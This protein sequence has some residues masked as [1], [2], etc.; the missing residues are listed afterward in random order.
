MKT[1]K[2]IPDI[3][4]KVKDLDPDFRYV[5]F[6]D[7]KAFVETHRSLQNYSSDVAS[8]LYDGFFDQ[9]AD[10]RTIAVRNSATILPFMEDSDIITL[11][12]RV[13]KKLTVSDPN[14]QKVADSAAVALRS[15]ANVIKSFSSERHHIFHSAFNTLLS[16]TSKD[17][18]N[19]RISALE[20]L[21]TL[22]P[23]IE[24][25][26]LGCYSNLDG[27]FNAFLANMCHPAALVR[28]SCVSCLSAVASILPSKYLLE[29]MEQLIRMLE[30]T[31]NGLA[32][33][34]S[35][36]TA[37]KEIIRNTGT[38]TEKFINVLF[39]RSFELCVSLIPEDFSSAIGI[40]RDLQDDTLEAGLLLISQ[41]FVSFKD[42]QIHGLNDLIKQITEKCLS[43]MKFD[44][45]VVH[46]VPE[47][48]EHGFDGEGEFDDFEDF[49][50]E[51]GGEDEF[52][53]E[54]ETTDSSWKVRKG[55]VNVIRG[56]IDCQSFHHV[57]DDVSNAGFTIIS[58]VISWLQYERSVL[59]LSD[60]FD[61]CRTLVTKF[62]QSFT[63]EQA[64]ILL[65]S[66]AQHIHPAKDTR[67]EFVAF[68]TAESIVNSLDLEPCLVE[69]YSK[70]LEICKIKVQGL[71]VNND[72]SLCES[73]FGFICSTYSKIL[74][75]KEKIFNV[76]SFSFI[77][78]IVPFLSPIHTALLKS[79]NK[80][81]VCLSV[82]ARYLSHSDPNFDNIIDLLGQNA[83]KLLNSS[84]VDQTCK[85]SVLEL[86]KEVSIQKFD[87]FQ[88]ILIDSMIEKVSL[89]NLPISLYALRTFTTILNHFQQDSTRLR[90]IPSD[91]VFDAINAALFHL[92]MVQVPH[93]QA[94]LNFLHSIFWFNSGFVEQFSQNEQIV[95]YLIKTLNS[96]NTNVGLI[97]S[98]LA[99]ARYFINNSEVMKSIISLAK[100]GIKSP[101]LTQILI[102]VA[103][104]N[105][106][107]IEHLIF[108]LIQGKSFDVSFHIGHLLL[109]QNS[110]D[111]PELTEKL[112]GFVAENFST[113]SEAVIN[114]LYSLGYVSQ[115]IDLFEEL[116]VVV[117]EIL[118]NSSNQSFSIEFRSA[119][120][121][122]IGSF[123]TGSISK[124]LNNFTFPN[125]KK[126]SNNP[127][128]L[129]IY[130]S[131][132]YWTVSFMRKDLLNYLPDIFHQIIDPQL[133]SAC[134]G[135]VGQS[136][137]STVSDIIGRLLL[138]DPNQ[139]SSLVKSS[140]DS[141]KTCS[142]LEIVELIHVVL[143]NGLSF[144]LS[145]RSEINSVLAT[146]EICTV[147]DRSTIADVTFPVVLNCLSYF[148]DNISILRVCCEYFS[149]VLHSIPLV[150]SKFI[151]QELVD[152]FITQLNFKDEKFQKFKVKINIGP[153]PIEI[154]HHLPLRRL[155]IDVLSQLAHHDL[156]STP[157]VSNVLVVFASQSFQDQPEAAVP[158][159]TTFKTL[160]RD[161]RYYDTVATKAAPHAAYSIY[162]A[163][164]REK[165]EKLSPDESSLFDSKVKECLV[166][167]KMLT[168]IP[169]INENKNVKSVEKMINGASFKHKKL[170]S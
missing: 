122:L 133:L 97:S 44:P 88:N 163:L 47:S 58:S 32:V 55:S 90:S 10:V 155:C 152:Y 77:S 63:N 7:L 131:G 31:P 95:S 139:V 8:A 15:T 150:F 68:L 41:L 157:Q 3:L 2:P 1:A 96:G 165:P 5:A 135:D 57:F 164:R 154:D 43:W 107:Q 118:K 16:L 129:T 6:M 54:E 127:S 36:L 105:P 35:V 134:S 61:L 50:E 19:A 99:V 113:Q 75:C 20:C 160:A 148:P 71:E 4:P 158:A 128:L 168:Q 149:S 138:I 104:Q 26:V 93:Q 39:G 91:T 11:F 114:S 13:S 23:N 112:K 124:S 73:M 33:S 66:I 132:L 29:V 137:R 72:M 70:L 48:M 136:I 83:L 146:D 49:Q 12:E 167:F 161:S 106:T 79:L 159:I 51:F 81:V 9:I 117:D 103:K 22:L 74:S 34:K 119:L 52:V 60:V 140:L 82:L 169:G 147:S 86:V 98:C 100:Q 170:L 40:E 42:Q 62:H 141:I 38:S 30:G 121:W 78:A 80:V 65:E 111:L 67:L 142:N 166:V 125:I 130:F 110:K 84:E 85:I 45:N 102:H 120:S 25:D 89:H 18:E 46:E 101:T 53:S 14:E 143:I 115:K 162:E 21:A 126:F 116:V 64:I 108:E 87:L 123:T 76:E 56:L 37:L 69:Y 151:S 28:K 92:S 153:F 27:L 144:S 24:P 94:A 156:L 17:A 109:N 59:V 145:Q